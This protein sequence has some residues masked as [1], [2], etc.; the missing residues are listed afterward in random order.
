[1]TAAATRN[2]SGFSSSVAISRLRLIATARA[3]MFASWHVTD[4]RAD[5]TAAV[6]VPSNA[7]IALLT[8]QNLRQ[9]YPPRLIALGG[10]RPQQRPLSPVSRAV[11]CRGEA[12]DEPTGETSQPRVLEELCW[13]CLDHDCLVT[14]SIGCMAALST[15]VHD[16]VETQL[17]L[18]WLNS[19]R[20]FATAASASTV[21]QGSFSPSATSPSTAPSARSRTA[22]TTSGFRCSG[23]NECSLVLAFPSARTCSRASRSL[24]I[25]S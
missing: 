4:W 20:R 13:L 19:C 21:S 17:S 9:T 1:M 7:P 2:V 22:T 25:A 23:R 5:I 14:G 10:E 16:N 15:S 12:R 8:H 11:V 3:L 6:R 18:V 24:K